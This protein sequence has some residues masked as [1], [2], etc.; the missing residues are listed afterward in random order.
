M[1]M[2]REHLH[3]YETVQ[4]LDGGGDDG[5]VGYEATESFGGRSS[6]C[7]DRLRQNK[8]KQ[9]TARHGT[10]RHPRHV[11]TS[12]NEITR[13]SWCQQDRL[14]NEGRRSDPSQGSREASFV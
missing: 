1:R 10:A 12:S 9:G 7:D 6:G 8:T 14:N 3:S 13:L 2:T 5:G 11:L 4:W